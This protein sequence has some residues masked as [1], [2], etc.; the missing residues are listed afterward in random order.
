LC[1]FFFWVLAAM[2]AADIQPQPRRHVV[3]EEVAGLERL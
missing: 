1:R 2:V 3:V